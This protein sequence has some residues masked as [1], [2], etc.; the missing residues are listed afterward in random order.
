MGFP[1]DN[2][3]HRS[4]AQPRSAP[5]SVRL[6]SAVLRFG[7]RGSHA[8]VLYDM[9]LR[10]EPLAQESADEVRS[11][12]ALHAAAIAAALTGTTS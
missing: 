2:I 12:L 11:S 5:R 1:Q 9:W 10:G 4:Q 8:G 6:R 7:R 3:Q